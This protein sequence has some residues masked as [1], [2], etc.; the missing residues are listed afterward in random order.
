MTV[1]CIALVFELVE[2]TIVLQ[3]SATSAEIFATRIYGAFAPFL[4]K[5]IF[6]NEPPFLGL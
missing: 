3:Q 6:E 1:A 4:E 2:R 5:K